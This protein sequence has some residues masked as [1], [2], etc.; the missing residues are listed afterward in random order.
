MQVYLDNQQFTYKPQNQEIGIITN[1]IYKQR[2]DLNL[3]EL[4]RSR[5]SSIGG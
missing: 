5:P 4:G 2:A 1:K 3:T